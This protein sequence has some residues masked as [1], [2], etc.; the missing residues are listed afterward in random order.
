MLEGM[1]RKWNLP[2][3]LVRM[4]AGTTT[5]ENSMEVTEK[6]IHRPYD[7]AIPLLGI[8]SDKTLLKKDTYT[9][10][11]IAALFTIVKTWKQPKCP[12]TDNWIW[13]M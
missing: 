5:M 4:E 10:M 7:P 1:S 9:R 3:L 8:Y 2:A 6:T 13:K 12:S 11:F